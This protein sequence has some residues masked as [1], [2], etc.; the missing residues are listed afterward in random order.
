M[1]FTN[2]SIGARLLFT[3]GLVSGLFIFALAFTL[4]GTDQIS[5][6]FTHFIEQDQKRLETL[7]TMQAEGSQVVIATAKKV[8]VPTLQPPLR[9]ASSSVAVFNDS[10]LE[11]TRLYGSLPDGKQVIDEIGGVW[12]GVST[13]AIR[14]IELVE[15]NQQDAARALF[16]D[17]VQKQWGW[18]RKQIQPLIKQEAVRVEQARQ[19]V[20]DQVERIFLWG[21]IFSLCAL[22]GGLGLNFISSRQ[23]VKSV[24][25]SARGMLNIAEGDGDLTRRLPEVGGRELSELASGF[26]QFTANVQGL[27]G[28]IANSSE[29]MT[30]LSQELKLA[31]QETSST[32]GEQESAMDQVATAMTEMTATVQ[33]VAQNAATAADAA[34]R[35]DQASGR[36]QRVVGETVASIDHLNGAVEQ[37][38]SNM[39]GLEKETEQIGLVLSVIK[40]IAEQ[41]NL[42]ALNAA[43][44][45]AR[46]GEQ[47]R[48]FA[49]VADEV[50]TL[51]GRTQSSTQEINQIIER[52]QS[53]AS[54][55]SKTMLASQQSAQ[56]TTTMAAKAVDSLNEI[57]TAVEQ[58]RDMNV[59][60][61]SAAEEQ[62][63]VSE[64]I[65]KNI[66][67]IADLAK[68]SAET[69]RRTDAVGKSLSG[70]SEQVHS[71]VN[72]F[73]F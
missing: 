14:A 64:D 47:G 62:G 3:I 57:T 6:E 19:R 69:A 4:Y 12:P 34:E 53:G 13:E 21:V 72:R 8:L 22:G 43:I 70:L 7:R 52:L 17:K 59:Q 50:R 28:E 48:G 45:A 32:V 39:R 31:A 35:A 49:V 46:A 1:F 73:R 29:R 2:W 68:Q 42:L 67:S 16:M 30:D 10:M 20:M 9:V 51:A 18:I 44:E 24:C 15:R 38:V 60:I 58:I 56:E 23:I 40:E 66:H 54:S 63:A 71:L 65:Q 55:T 36:G 27:V 33:N 5:E 11:A 41:T 37:A 25:D 61:A 26:N